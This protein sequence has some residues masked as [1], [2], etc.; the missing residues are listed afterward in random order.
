MTDLLCYD[1]L[2]DDNEKVPAVTMHNG[3]ALCEECAREWAA[4]DQEARE[5][6]A[7]LQV[8]EIRFPPG[9]GG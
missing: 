2:T 4:H 6:I 5:Q 7:N 9:M 1:C 3:N 8:P